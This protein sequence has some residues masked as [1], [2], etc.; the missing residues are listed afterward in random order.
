MK[1]SPV[2]TGWAAMTAPVLTGW[3]AMTA[4]VIPLSVHPAVPASAHRGGY[5]LNGLKGAAC[6]SSPPAP[7]LPRVPAPG[8]Q[9]PTKGL[10]GR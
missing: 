7:P 1:N 2:P 4:P 10:A 9:A 5:V 8:T 6:L 3:A